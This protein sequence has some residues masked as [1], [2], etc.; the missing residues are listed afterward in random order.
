MTRSAAS[1]LS[2]VE[3]VASYWA[4]V[5]RVVFAATSRDLAGYDFQDLAIYAQLGL[6]PES[7]SMLEDADEKGAPARRPHGRTRL[8]SAALTCPVL[9]LLVI[10]SG[11]ARPG[12][13]A[14]AGTRRWAR[15]RTGA[16][17]PS[18]TCALG[19]LRRPAGPD[20][21][22]DRRHEPQR[23]DHYHGQRLFG[24]PSVFGVAA[25][26]IPESTAS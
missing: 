17:R 15:T 7:R 9:V 5:S 25:A 4:P 13:P 23:P 12:S 16:A 2:A 21:C 20:R 8:G 11:R 22:R 1:V 24:D 18:T 14:P 6:P 26:C 10:V 3:T 19:W